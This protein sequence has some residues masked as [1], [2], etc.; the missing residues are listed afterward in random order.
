MYLYKDNCSIFLNLKDKNNICTLT[1]INSNIGNYL[2]AIPKM[3]EFLDLNK[4][5]EVCLC[6]NDEF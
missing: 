6:I 2:Y 3:I 5:L 1:N 4:R